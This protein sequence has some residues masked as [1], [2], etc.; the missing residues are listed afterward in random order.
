MSLTNDLQK[1][2]HDIGKQNISNGIQSKSSQRYERRVIQPV[3][4]EG[5]EVEEQKQKIRTG[6]I[7][8]LGISHKEGKQSDP[9]ISYLMF[10]KIYSMHSYIKNKEEKNSD[11]LLSSMS[12]HE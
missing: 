9:N 1:V 6:M 12:E 5:G 4:R 11:I 7:N 8:V 2:L 10:H 3:N